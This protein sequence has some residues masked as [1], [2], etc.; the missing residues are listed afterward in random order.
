[1]KVFV[2]FLT[3]LLGSP[4][5][6]LS[7]ATVIYDG[8]PSKVQTTVPGEKDFWLTVSD[9]TR[10]SGFVLKPQ[11]A[12]LDQLCIPI[13][14]ARKT[15]FLRREGGKEWFNLS[16]L[17]RALRQPV[18]RDEANA[19]WFIGPRPDV[20]T[21]YL[22]TLETPNFTLPDWKGTPRSLTDFRGRKVLLIT[23]ASW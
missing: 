5:R 21:Q 14:K 1:M 2:L 13:P 3:A 19:V 7:E 16:E 8:K 12:C 10:V 20:L 4:A 18:A 11:G 15:A 22:E 23:W 17:A 9:L 6:G